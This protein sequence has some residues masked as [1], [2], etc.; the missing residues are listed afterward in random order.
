M[1]SRV[2]L[3]DLK[4]LKIQGARGQLDASGLILPCCFSNS[5]NSTQSV[6]TDLITDRLLSNIRSKRNW[7]PVLYFN[8][9][10]KMMPL[11]A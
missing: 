10:K 11:S 8:Y 4:I 7:Q 9:W 3:L 1:S 6:A 5:I 2:G